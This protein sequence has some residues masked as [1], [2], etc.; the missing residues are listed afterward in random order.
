MARRIF[1]LVYRYG[2]P[3]PGA[4]KMK[5]TSLYP[6]IFYHEVC[7]FFL[8]LSKARKHILFILNH[9]ITWGTCSLR[10]FIRFIHSLFKHL[11]QFNKFGNAGKSRPSEIFQWKTFGKNC[12]EK[13]VLSSYIN[14]K[15]RETLFAF[16]CKFLNLRMKIF[17]KN[18][19]KNETSR[20][21]NVF[22]NIS[23]K[24]I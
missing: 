15:T 3:N 1:I 18:F 14:L 2:H 13:N 21:L 19:Q 22:D 5:Y 16:L 11:K 12:Q 10:D 7:S 6:D 9:S 20:L 17:E 4:Q 23:F 24:E 8:N